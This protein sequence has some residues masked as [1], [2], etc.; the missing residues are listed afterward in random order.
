MVLVTGS[1]CSPAVVI[2]TLTLWAEGHV[3]PTIEHY[4]WSGWHQAFLWGAYVAGLLM[5]VARA[6]RAAGGFVLS[7]ARMRRRGRFKLT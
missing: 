7:L 3:K 4:N 2:L 1:P 6:A 5:L